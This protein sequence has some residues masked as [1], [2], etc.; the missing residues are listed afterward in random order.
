MLEE[1]QKAMEEVEARKK[2]RAEELQSL[3]AKLEVLKV[4]KH[5]MVA[6]LKQVRLYCLL[7]TFRSAELRLTRC[8]CIQIDLRA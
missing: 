6:Q 8:L 3:H 4:E 7:L 1:Q 2:R 5:E